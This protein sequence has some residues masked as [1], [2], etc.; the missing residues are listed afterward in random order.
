MWQSP[1]Q[2]VRALANARKRERERWLQPF[3][4]RRVEADLKLVTPGVPTGTSAEPQQVPARVV[5]NDLSPKGIGLFTTQALIADQEIILTIRQPREI[6][7]KGRVVSCQEYDSGSHILSE[8]SF[9]HRIGVRF[10]LESPEQEKAIT[11]LY[12]D[13]NREYLHGSKAA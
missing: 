4:I 7:L 3:H 13:L 1:N 2:R 12:N 5:L 9:T 11:D 8:Q 10:L 6:T